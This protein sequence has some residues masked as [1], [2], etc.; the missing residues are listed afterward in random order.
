MA[1]TFAF[2]SDPALTTRIKSSVF[3]TQ[4]TVTPLAED[5]VIYFGSPHATH[6]CIKTGGVEIAISDAAVGTGSPAANFKLATSAAG[7]DTATGG[8]AL[9]IG[10][11]IL[12]GID[13]AVAIHL[14]V[15]DTTHVAGIKT[16]LSLVLNDPVEWLY[17]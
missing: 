14:R 11:Q 12:G 1:T 4:S 3:F 8:A 5:R 15:L 6:R 2:F 10:T 16:D 13:Q 7:L 17:E 9:N